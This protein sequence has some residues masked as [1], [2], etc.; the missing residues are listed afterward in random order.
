MERYDRMMAAHRSWLI[1]GFQLQVG[2]RVR[3]VGKLCTARDGKVAE[4]GTSHSGAVCY[5]LADGGMFSANELEL[6]R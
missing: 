2:D 3:V 4:I 5:H 1:D 6:R